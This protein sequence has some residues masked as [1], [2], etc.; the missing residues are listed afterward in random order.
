MQRQGRQAGLMGRQH[1]QMKRLVLAPKTRVLLILSV[2]IMLNTL[3][4]L[5]MSFLMVTWSFFNCLCHASCP[6]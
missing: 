1:S 5:Q 2:A 6:L 4:N 3:E